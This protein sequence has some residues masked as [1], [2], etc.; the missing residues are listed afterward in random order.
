MVICGHLSL[1]ARW[2]RRFARDYR[3][4]GVQTTFPARTKQIDITPLRRSTRKTPPSLV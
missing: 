4:G 3:A 2:A 1:M